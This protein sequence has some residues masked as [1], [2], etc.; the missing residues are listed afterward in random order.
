MNEKYLAGR[1]LKDAAVGSTSHDRDTFAYLHWQPADHVFDTQLGPLN[2]SQSLPA[3]VSQGTN[4][5]QQQ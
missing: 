5:W 4:C 2:A 1:A 3:Q